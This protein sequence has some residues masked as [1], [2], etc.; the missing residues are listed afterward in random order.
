MVL[1]ERIDRQSAHEILGETA[2]DALD[3]ERVFEED[4][5]ADDRVT[6]ALSEAEIEPRRSDC[7]HGRR[8]GNRRTDG[9][10]ESAREERQVSP[11]RSVVRLP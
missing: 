1:A 2:S 6:D 8:R 11:S 5:L 10:G 3:S 7:L 4:L 9:S